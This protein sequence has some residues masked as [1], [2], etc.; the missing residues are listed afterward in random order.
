MIRVVAIILAGL[1]FSPGAQALTFGDWIAGYT[2]SDA[3]PGA[4]PDGDG[5]VNLVEFVLAGCDPSKSDA[6][7]G[8]R[9]VFGTRATG[10]ALPYH[11]PASI[12]YD[13]V[14]PP[15]DEYWYLGI[16]WT[17]RAGIEGVEVRPQFAWWGS[18]LDAWLDGPST[19]LEPVAHAGGVIAWM[20]GMFRPQGRPPKG[21][22]RLKVEE[23]P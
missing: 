10:T 23:R 6:A 12:T 7:T 3:A 22:V 17:P 1:L 16:F 20:Q 19:F 14:M 4:D 21:H 2:V 5:L 18:N 15:F 13:G 8:T 11:D 9:M